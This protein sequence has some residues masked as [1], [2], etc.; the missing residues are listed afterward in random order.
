MA[1]QDKNVSLC[2]AIHDL[3]HVIGKEVSVPCPG[4]VILQ[5]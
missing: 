3:R 5:C 1:G 4:D 2:P